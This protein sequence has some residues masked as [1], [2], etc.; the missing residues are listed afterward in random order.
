MAWKLEGESFTS[1]RLPYAICLA[2]VYMLY[3]E[4][5]KFYL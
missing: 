5:L 2:L 3:A 1:D 4:Q